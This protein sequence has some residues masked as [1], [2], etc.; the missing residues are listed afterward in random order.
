MED[1]RDETN[2]RC[3]INQTKITEDGY[4]ERGQGGVAVSSEETR[5]GSP[6]V[7][8]NVDE[9]IR[10]YAFCKDCNQDH[11]DPSFNETRGITANGPYKANDY[12][13]THLSRALQKKVNFDLE[14]MGCPK[15]VIVRV[16]AST[17]V[18]EP[19]SEKMYEAFPN[20]PKSFTPTVMCIL[21][22][23]ED[24]L[25]FIMYVRYYGL[26]CGGPNQAC[27]YISY[28]DSLRHFYLEKFPLMRKTTFQA[29]I[30]ALLD[31]ESSNGYKR[32]YIWSSAPKKGDNYIFRHAPPPARATL[33]ENVVE[34]RTKKRSR[35]QAQIDIEPD[36]VNKQARL[37]DFYKSIIHEGKKLGVVMSCTTVWDE[38]Q[39]H[40]MDLSCV[41]YFW[42]CLI[43]LLATK[44]GLFK[45]SRNQQPRELYKYVK[46]SLAMQKD[47]LFVINLN[48]VLSSEV[49]RAPDVPTRSK[50]L[51]DRE[52]FL[53]FSEQ[54]DV[55]FKCVFLTKRWTSAIV[56]LLLGEHEEREVELFE[57]AHSCKINACGFENCARMRNLVKVYQGYTD[58]SRCEVYINMLCS[59]ARICKGDC[60][61]P[62]CAVAKLCARE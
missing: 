19:V 1:A 32:C 16:C 27:M 11:K 7:A 9:A 10:E 29:L 5:G 33:E 54:N 60:K 62:N 26:N 2:T 34:S 45:Q 40:D 13:E 36:Q 17:A 35:L 8:T 49:T 50:L 41:P 24:M 38:I 58:P 55:D 25:V 53:K 56:Q 31:F 39:A 42:G 46:S 14:E 3:G 22:F 20:F 61:I 21:L 28:L 18:S 59:H 52:K 4:V 15:K 44:R 23:W 51:E 37:N 12:P 43:D 47:D 30:L 6:S 57:H 48:P